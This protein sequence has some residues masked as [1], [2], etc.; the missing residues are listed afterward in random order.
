[1]DDELRDAAGFQDSEHLLQRGIHL[2]V[3]QRILAADC[4]ETACFE[5]KILRGDARV[6]T[7]ATHP[8]SGV[9][10]IAHGVNQGQ[11]AGMDFPMSV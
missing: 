3:F 9:R 6:E 5:W 4:V 11:V 1:M 8:G 7:D 2:C 10:D